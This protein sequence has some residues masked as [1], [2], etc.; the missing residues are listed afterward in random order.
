MN[1]P[2]DL[3]SG[4]TSTIW[5]GFISATNAV[6]TGASHLVSATATGAAHLVYRVF[7]TPAKLPT[8][9]FTPGGEEGTVTI[10]QTQEEPIGDFE[11]VDALTHEEMQALRARQPSHTSTSALD[12][13]QLNAEWALFDM[14]APNQK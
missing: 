14:L 5:E 13:M 12:V 2:V 11:L 9:R 10:E 7:G 1:S 3:I 4:T 8:I 6:A